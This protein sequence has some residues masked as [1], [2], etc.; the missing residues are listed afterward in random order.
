MNH[1][2]LSSALKAL[3]RD[4]PSLCA[5]TDF[6]PRFEAQVA[7]LSAQAEDPDDALYVIERADTMLGDLGIDWGRGDAID[8]RR[9]SAASPDRSS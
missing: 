6:Q 4:L 3:E 5:G 2:Q 7:R 8:P 9:S 1:A